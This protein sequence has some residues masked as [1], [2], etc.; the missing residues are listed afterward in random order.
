[1]LML[2]RCVQ[3]VLGFGEEKFREIAGSLLVTDV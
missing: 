3:H 2:G 1:M